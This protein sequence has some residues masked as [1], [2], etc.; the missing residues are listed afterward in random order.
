MFI[1]LFEGA[2][3]KSLLDVQACQGMGWA[4]SASPGET[5][6]LQ[7]PLQSCKAAPPG[8]HPSITALHN[9][10]NAKE[11][12]SAHNQEQLPS[13]TKPKSSPSCR[14]PRCGVA[15]SLR[16]ALLLA[17]P[18]SFSFR[19]DTPDFITHS[20]PSRMTASAVPQPPAL[21]RGRVVWGSEGCISWCAAPLYAP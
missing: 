8:S 19:T 12:G 10:F 21:S 20:V 15:H 4:P 16:A 2:A 9:A 18:F 13:C 14:A 11:P 5:L 7:E 3:C 6:S 17:P 1:P